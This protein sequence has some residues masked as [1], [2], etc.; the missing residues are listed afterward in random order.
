MAC[1]EACGTWE[2]PNKWCGVFNMPCSPP[3]LSCSQSPRG[4]PHLPITRAL[5]WPLG[6]KSLSRQ[7]TVTCMEQVSPS[8]I[9]HWQLWLN[10]PEPEEEKEGRES[11][12]SK[13]MEL[14]V[15]CVCLA[16]SWSPLLSAG[17]VL[18]NRIFCSDG[19]VL[20]LHCPI[21]Q[22]LAACSLLHT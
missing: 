20:Y 3:R 6:C 21:W 10:R 15:R 4:W 1:V 22:T 13:A 8:S 7:W 16:T 9:S 11:S 5:S 19:S 12:E 14:S 18:S 17:A 2:V